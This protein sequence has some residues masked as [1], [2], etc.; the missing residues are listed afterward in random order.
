MKKLLLI[1]GALAIAATTFAQDKKTF[2]TKF[3][4]AGKRVMLN[5]NAKT[6]SVEAYDG[7][8]VIIEAENIPQ[9]PKEAD[10]LRP[11]GVGGLDNTQIGL[12]VNVVDNTLKI[13]TVLKGEAIYKLRLP[14]ELGLQIKSNNSWCCDGEVPLR[15]QGLAGDIE[16]ATNQRDLEIVDVTG[17][18]VANSQQGKIKIV[19]NDKISEKPSNIV[20]SGDNID[21]T[22]SE[23]VNVLFTVAAREGNFFTDVDL[24][25][26]NP[27]AKQSGKENKPDE[28]GW[29][30]SKKV[31][32]ETLA[33]MQASV[34]QANVNVGD[35]LLDVYRKEAWFNNSN[36]T[37][38]LL[39]E[40]KTIISI[41][42][43]HGN[44][45]LRKKK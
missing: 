11:V 18:I 4:G 21:I 44:V 3:S 38:Y 37:K 9:I 7:D 31:A 13:N 33:Q 32:N 45:Y 30:D 27:P 41:Q 25:P 20:A 8:E 16:V 28:F 43:T 1:V 19:F 5:L 39:N 12:S 40:P 23:K 29:T 15:I 2:K 17:P 22:I 35:A 42:T 14:R 24:K 34:A 6:I 26:Y 10:G 36:F